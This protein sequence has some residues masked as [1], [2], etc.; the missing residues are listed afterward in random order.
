MHYPV[1]RE[2]LKRGIHVICDKPLT[3]TLA[4]AKKLAKAAEASGALFVLTH[5]YTGYP[6]VRQAREMVQGGELGTDPLVQVE[7]PQD[8]LTEPLE[9]NR[10]ETGGL[11]H[12]SG[13]LG[14]WAARPAT[15]APMPS[16]W[17]FRDS[18]LELGSSRRSR[19]L[20]SKA[21]SSMTTATCM[22]RFARA[23]PRACCGQARSRRAMRT[24]LKLRSMATRAG[25]NGRR[26]TRT[27]SGIHRSANP[28]S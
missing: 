22:M 18:G 20:S 27:I 19:Q 13:A 25:W 1:A 7:Y 9:E 2:F 21:A 8:W 12:R 17:Q 28:N 5:N 24:A 4:D 14:R 16:T 15:S 3:S 10:A 23:A 11:A 6:M 26:K